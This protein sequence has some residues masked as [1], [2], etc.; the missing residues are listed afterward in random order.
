MASLRIYLSSTFEDLKEHRAVV[1]EA[2]EKAGLQIGRMEGYVASDQRPLDLCLKDVERSDIYVG[3]FAWRYGYIPPAEHG[4][5]DGHSITEL[6]YRLAEKHRKCRLIFFADPTTEQN[7]PERFRDEK[8]AEGNSG[9]RIKALKRELAIE[10]TASFFTTPHHLASLVLAAILR[11]EVIKRPFMVPQLTEGLV[12]RPT[13]VSRLREALLADDKEPIAVEGSG[14][15][16]KTTLVNEACHDPEVIR[17]FSDGILWAT[18]GQHPNLMG[19]LTAIYAALTDSRPN[20]AGSED[21]K[22]SIAEKLEGHRHLLVVDDVWR[23]SDLKIFQELGA[24]RVLYTTRRRDLALE[25]TNIEVEEMAPEESV[26]LL[27]RDLAVTEHL[28]LTFIKFADELGN[29]PLLLSLTNARLRRES[30]ERSSLEKAIDRVHEVLHRRGVTGFDKRDAQKRDEAIRLSLEAGLEPFDDRFRERAAT[31]GLFPEDIPLPVDVLVMLWGC[32]SFEAEEDVLEPLHNLRIITWDRNSGVVNSHDVI[33]AALALQVNDRR[34]EHTKLLEAWGDPYQLC[35]DYAWRYYSYHLRG[36][37]KLDDL[38]RLILDSAWVR[39]KLN[40]TDIHSLLSDFDALESPEEEIQ[41]LQNALRLST[42]VLASNKSEL[43][44][45]LLA[46]LPDS[47]MRLR[48]KII[49]D[50]EHARLPWLRPNGISLVSAGGPLIRS[51]RAPGPA[52]IVS[53]T[54]GVQL[55][56]VSPDSTLMIWNTD[57]GRCMRTLELTSV[58]VCAFLLSPDHTRIITVSKD[59]TF[60]VLNFTTGQCIHTLNRNNGAIRCM[61]ISSDGEKLVSASH[62]HILRVWELE[63]GRCIQILESPSRQA[64]TVKFTPDGTQ[65]LAAQAA[66]E[67]TPDGKRLITASYNHLV[68]LWDLRSGQLTNTVFVNADTFETVVD[69]PDGKC[70]QLNDWWAVP[71]WDVEGFRTASADESVEPL[72]VLEGHTNR[73]DVLMLST[74]AKKLITGSRDTTIKVWDLQSGE[75]LQ[76]LEGHSNR[77]SALEF[78]PDQKRLVSGAEDKTLKVWDL[79]TGKC[80]TTLY[81]HGGAVGAIALTSSGKHVISASDDATVKVWDLTKHYPNVQLN[82][83]RARISALAVT[84]NDKKVISG[85]FDGGMKVWDFE[86]HECLY[87]LEAHSGEINA[88]GVTPDGKTIVSGSSDKLLKVWNLESGE[89]RATLAGHDGEIYT[90]ALSGDGKQIVSGSEDGTLRVWTLDNSESISILEGHHWQ[91]VSSI[92]ISSDGKR[93]ISADKFGTL[94]IWNFNTGQC[95]ATLEGHTGVVCA[96]LTSDG[97]TIISRSNDNVLKIWDAETGNCLNALETYGW[98][99]YFAFGFTAPMSKH[100]VALSPDNTVTVWNL[101]SRQNMYSTS[102]ARPPGGLYHFAF[103]VGGKSIVFGIDGLKQA[104]LVVVWDLH[105]GIPLASFTPEAAITVCTISKDPSKIILG[106]RGGSIHF[107]QLKNLE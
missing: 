101:E 71:V 65:L 70:L 84:P 46:R 44:S 98:P 99:F 14:G 56:T 80:L 6:E 48:E 19:E 32:D 81:G 49:A 39:A 43:P 58:D 62:D 83:H 75:C 51:L 73:V 82:R 15:F 78:T 11:Q 25:T 72:M 105:M 2:L 40:A 63:T 20:F 42:H 96:M 10:K 34:S 95:I 35:S 103:M 22:R 38:R 93:M 85:S 91:S 66:F 28:R 57:N 18:L 16:G 7:W 69:E 12:S 54:Q 4:N 92:S 13:K 104:E 27:M 90:I 77:I 37:G 100:I 76:T 74:D 1:F 24:A 79:G 41:L 45:Q 55:L 59:G 53:T 5:P 9:A 23:I 26:E 29:W 89:C 47:A 8:T 61:A 102:F 50:M 60:N 17:E 107:L 21:A 97:R 64:F 67:F 88:I 86:S 36:A 33:R 3:I 106:D 94:R 52:Y 31:I 87:T 30:K 68:E